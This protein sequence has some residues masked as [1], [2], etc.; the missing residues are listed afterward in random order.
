MAPA[1]SDLVAAV[2]GLVISPEHDELEVALR[3]ADRLEAKISSAL[4]DFDEKEGWREDGSLSLTAWLAHHGRRSRRDAHRE[5]VTARRLG[6]LPATKAAWEG[7]KLSSGQVAAVM[8]NVAERHLDLFAEQEEELVEAFQELSAS[9]TAAAMHHWRLRAD[10]LDENP[11][12]RERPSQLHLAA[13]LDG[14]REIFG[15]L[16]AEDAAVVEEA[17]ADA[18]QEPA[19]GE[20]QRSPSELRA[21]ALVEICRRF[22]ADHGG[23]PASRNRPCVNIVVDLDDLL[24][25]GPGHMADG[26][27]VTP[28][29]VSWL[30]CDSELHRLV[31]AGRS[32]VLDYGRATR[33]ISPSLWSALVIRDAHCRHPGCDRPPAWCEGHHVVHFSKGGP[34]RLSNLVMA[35]SRH[36]HLWHEPGWSLTLDEDATLWIVTPWG[37]TLASRPP[38]RRVLA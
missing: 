32:S 20:G 12:A 35:C 15:H 8:A 25:D 11:P 10:A 31:V 18:I 9:E 16:K 24:R 4:R 6:A 3:A 37:T 36:H 30:A 21:D 7:G 38:P 2:D 22:L 1:V 14:R 33:T 29:V 17:L 34:T 23:P 5:A 19:A 28:D 27:W 13:T 26:T